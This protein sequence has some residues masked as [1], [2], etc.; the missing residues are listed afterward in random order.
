MKLPHRSFFLLF[1]SLTL[2]SA[3]PQNPP[4]LRPQDVNKK[5]AEILDAH[6]SYNKLTPELMGKA[7]SN[8]IDQLDPAKSYL[9][10]EEIEWALSPSSEELEALLASYGRSDFSTFEQLYREMERAIVRRGE[11]EEEIDQLTLP[12]HVS[13]VEF[14]DP[15]WCSSVEELRERLLRLRSL[16]ME[17]AR[18]ASAARFGETMERI[19]QRRVR[20]EESLF[21]LKGEKRAQQIRVFLLKALA[22]A[23]DAQTAYF[24]PQEAEEFAIQLQQRLYG[25]GVQLRE[26]IDG[27][28]IVQV[29]EGGPSEAQGEIRANDRVVAVNG[30]TVV[31]MDINDFVRL[32][33]GEAGSQVQ[34]TLLREVGKGEEKHDERLEVEITRGEVV[35]KET[36]IEAS[37]TPFGDGVI[38]NIA[39]HSFYQDE[40]HSSA[41]DLREEFEKLKAQHKIKGVILDLRSNAGGLLPQ[42]IDVA[43]LFISKGI[44]AS[45]KVNG[46]KI[47]YLRDVDGELMWNGPLI[48]LVNRISASSAE[49]VAQALQDY[50]RALVVGDR[51]TFGKGTYQTLTIDLAG[52]RGFDPL[53]EYKVTRGMYYTV[54]GKSPQ[55]HGVKADIV[56]PSLFAELEIGE[57]FSKFPL[58]G[59]EIA[60][61]FHDDLSDV[62]LLHRPSARKSYHFDLQRR[63]TDYNRFL[64]Q[65]RANSERRI[66][67]NQNYQNFL[68]RVLEEEDWS[69][70]PPAFGL[71]DLQLEESVQIMADLLYLIATESHLNSLGAVS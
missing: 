8:F 54:S 4:A 52:E 12:S 41:G 55:L 57:Q 45:I 42:A 5:M 16:Q 66:A 21:H 34:L 17:M 24:T 32:V 70:E 2:L 49:I 47:Q 18:T 46:G 22:N 19:A 10:R 13:H 7:L 36:R 48:V 26:G 43:G 56:V 60:A 69:D 6:A 1:L 53:G 64:D 58:D 11:V 33:R 35:F 25:I 29:I 40:R 20:R 62:P 28:T 65:L 9:V 71:N 61:N 23:L 30:E 44:V 38:A 67:A 39:L 50:G 63:M 15:D 51:T 59:G 3:A 31:G 27:F 68:K 37:A 14:R